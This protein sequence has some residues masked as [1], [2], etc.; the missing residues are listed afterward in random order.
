MKESPNANYSD[1]EIK[2]LKVELDK[3][4]EELSACINQ[5]QL[6]KNDKCSLIKNLDE[7]EELAD[8]TKI[9]YDILNDKLSARELEIENLN[10]KLKN[11]EIEH[12]E[13]IK[14]YEMAESLKEESE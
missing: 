12:E 14:N 7:Y 8:K 1:S 6:L 9:L 3:T 10:Q 2:K 4:K 5:N 11:K 13:L